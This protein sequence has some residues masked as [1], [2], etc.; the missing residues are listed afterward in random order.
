MLREPGLSFVDAAL[1]SGCAAAPE[2]SEH[3]GELLQI[4]F[5]AK[6]R[7]SDAL[8][9]GIVFVFLIHDQSSWLK[10]M[11]IRSS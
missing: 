10:S 2:P 11:S 1:L 4:A 8:D 7:C 9:G 6:H 5:A 3:V